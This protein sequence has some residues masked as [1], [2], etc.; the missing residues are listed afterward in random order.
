[1]KQ[2]KAL[3]AIKLLRLHL[4]G[5]GSTNVHI[6]IYI[7]IYIY[8]LI[9]HLVHRLLTI[10]ARFPVLLEISVLKKTISRSI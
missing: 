8:I 10:V 7:Y 4:G 6:Y 5:R 3:G 1:M 2:K 9:E